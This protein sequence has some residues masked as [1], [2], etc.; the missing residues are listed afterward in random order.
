MT[1]G[2]LLEAIANGDAIEGVDLSAVDWKDLSG[3]EAKF[4]RCRFIRCRFAHTDLR[5][6]SFEDCIFTDKQA[7]VGATFAFTEMREARLIR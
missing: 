2:Q 6:A 4:I 1:T 5:A 3:A 7:S